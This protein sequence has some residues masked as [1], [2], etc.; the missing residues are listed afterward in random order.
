MTCSHKSRTTAQTGSNYQIDH[1]AQCGRYVV[2]YTEGMRHEFKETYT[3]L[4][5]AQ[6][7][8]TLPGLMEW[9]IPHAWEGQI[10]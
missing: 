5:E 3:T 10:P 6:A 4:N 8:C 2:T 1:C 7:F 9:N